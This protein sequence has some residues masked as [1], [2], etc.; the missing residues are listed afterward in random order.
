MP[1]NLKFS[2][3]ELPKNILH[4]FLVMKSIIIAIICFNIPGRKS[5]ISRSCKTCTQRCHD[6]Q[7]NCNCGGGGGVQMVSRSPTRSTRFGESLE[8]LLPFQVMIVNA[9]GRP[10]FYSLKKLCTGWN[11][12]W[13]NRLRVQTMAIY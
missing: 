7:V 1:M 2:Q 9:N 5:F 4:M 3:L 6:Y 10:R 11:A 12:L 13:Q 8:K